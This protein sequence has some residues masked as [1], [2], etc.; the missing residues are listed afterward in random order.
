MHK[1]REEYQLKLNNIEG[2][3]RKEVEDNLKKRTGKLYKQI[4]A[5]ITERLTRENTIREIDLEAMRS[6]FEEEY[7]AKVNAKHEEL[8]QRFQT[9][10]IEAAGDFS[11]KLSQARQAWGK[12]H[13]GALQEKTAE[14]A[15]KARAL[16]ERHLVGEQTVWPMHANAHARARAR[17]RADATITTT[18]PI[19][20]P[21]AGEGD[22]PYAGA[23]EG[24]RYT[25]GAHVRNAERG[26]KQRGQCVGRAAP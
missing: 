8:D 23:H 26:G 17:V 10:F 24:A 7:E 20:L 16:E 9:Q 6:E 13:M 11:L 14:Y 3:V 4:E 21:P 22:P 19:Y 12:E 1:I 15:E 2:R 25:S 18:S 5:E